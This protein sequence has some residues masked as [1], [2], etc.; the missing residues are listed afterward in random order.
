MSPPPLWLFW[1]FGLMEGMAHKISPEQSKDP[2]GG[3]SPR[4]RGSGLLSVQLPPRS[5]RGDTGPARAGQGGP[6]PHLAL[7]GSA[8][9]GVLRPR[10]PV[11]QSR[12]R[13]VRVMGC[14]HLSHSLSQAPWRPRPSGL[15]AGEGGS[16]S[17]RPVDALKPFVSIVGSVSACQGGDFP[18]RARGPRS[19][20]PAVAVGR[21]F[22]S[23]VSTPQCARLHGRLR[24]EGGRSLGL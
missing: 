23:L 19:R 21:S 5:V 6:F 7:S 18:W 1:A 24:V 2:G 10:P 20:G 14:E 9:C 11:W 15:E 12:G 4:G 17:R 8:C 13:G 3:G 22:S 16:T